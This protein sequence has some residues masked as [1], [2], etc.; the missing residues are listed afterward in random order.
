MKA[1][2]RASI[3][4][5]LLAA[6]SWALAASP[7]APLRFRV[8]NPGAELGE[9]P[10]YFPVKIAPGNYLVGPEAGGPGLAAQA[11]KDGDATYLAV[12]V[13]K[14]AHGSNAFSVTPAAT[15]AG[16]ASGVVLADDGPNVAVSVGGKPLTEYVINDGPRPFFFPVIGPGGD[17]M[18]RAY[19][20]K[21]V[22]GEK[23]DHPHHR[24]LWFTHG[25]VNGVDFWSEMPRHGSI[26]ETSRIT[27]VGGPAVGVLRTT[28]DWIG[29]D[30]KKVCEDERVVRFYNTKNTRVIDFDVDVRA[31]EGPLTFGDT[32]EGSFGMRMASTM[33]VTAKQ[34]GKITNAEG[35]TDDA[36]WGKPSPWVDYVG[37]VNGKTVGVAILNHPTSVRYPT[38][39]HVRTY[40][41]FAAN[42][43][44]YHDFDPKAGKKG[45]L[46]VPKGETV[47]FRHRIILHAGDTA[48]AQI[49][50]ANAAYASLTFAIEK[51]GP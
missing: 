38:T 11:V 6:P 30:G 25:N 29:P 34:G 14:L 51:P 41:L 2:I 23:R 48:M 50:S 17:L 10:I 39:W 49:P 24:S 36:T 7:V 42:P 12:V 32:K 16:D 22:E 13:P 1:M 4:L 21:D 44:G 15:D 20:M 40:G 35:L 43:F 33:D 18:T 31:T 3:A 45:D 26:K 8:E 47:R 37:P 27:K 19:P 9:T 28:D 5:V 46:T